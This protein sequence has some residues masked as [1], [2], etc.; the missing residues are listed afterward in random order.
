MSHSSTTTKYHER[1]QQTAELIARGRKVLASGTFDGLGPRPLFDRDGSTFPFLVSRAKGCRLHDTSG[2]RYVDWVNCWGDVL[3]GY[4]HPAINEA[5][6]TQMIAYP[7]LTMMHPVQIEVAELIS[8]M[9]P[10]GEQVWFCTNG[11]EACQAAMR[12]ARVATGRELIVQCGGYESSGGNSGEP[13][14]TSG[15][16]SHQSIR[17]FGFNDVESID[18]VF[19]KQAS[20]VAAIILEPMGQQLP[21]K[22]FLE[23]LR[24]IADHFAVL[25]IFDERVSGF[26]VAKGGAQQLLGVIP[27]LTCLGSGLANGMS[28]AALA[29]KRRYMQE[30][31]RCG[32]EPRFQQETLS[33]SIARTVLQ[34]INREH[35]IEHLSNAGQSLRDGLSELATRIGIE[36]S[37]IGHN[38]RMT[39]KFADIG[40]VPVEL[41]HTTFVQECMRH[42]VLTNGNFL[43]SYAHDPESIELTLNALEQSLQ[44]VGR[45]I[46]RRQP[47]TSA[48]QIASTEMVGSEMV[49]S[50]M[51]ESDLGQPTDDLPQHPQL[52]EQ[53]DADP[54][55]ATG[56]ASGPEDAVIADGYI[57]RIVDGE[58]MMLV[59]GWLLLEQGA[60]ESIEMV[61]ANGEVVNCKRVHR[62][63]LVPAFPDKEDVLHA[64]F[65]VSL[66]AK[67]FSVDGLFEF[68]LIAKFQQEVAFRAWVKIPGERHVQPPHSI[69]DGILFLG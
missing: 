10:S 66:A 27:D 5:I 53:A 25:L 26:R 19:N 4:H 6:K 9:V 36:S 49:G 40:S 30:L 15:N 16:S 62:P 63:D 23:R 18:A 8:E 35:V 58:G 13:V 67:K 39:I 41:V 64:G 29:G 60:A 28:L 37:L 50:E 42:G 17:Y 52:G 21:S 61:S 3:L 48:D 55:L 45:L 59:G 22:G 44:A 47:T 11:A 14:D 31:H 69:R 56:N 20:D 7:S 51:V 57:D 34:K 65:E 33:L 68:T 12:L 32:L 43:A 1:V 2:N 54:R 24:E 46:S 38:A